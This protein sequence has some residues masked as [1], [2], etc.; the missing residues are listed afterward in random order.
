M[1]TPNEF[2][3]S[4]FTKQES[5]PVAGPIPKPVDDLSFLVLNSDEV[6]AVPKE[7][8]PTKAQGPDRIISRVLKECN[9]ELA[10]DITAIFD[11]SIQ[12]GT[13]P[14]LWKRANVAPVFKKRDQSLPSN[15]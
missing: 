6:A 5:E 10:E 3:Q 4:V 11:D 14:N 8:N 15:Y 13:A 12:S 7:I 1:D 2:F 9:E